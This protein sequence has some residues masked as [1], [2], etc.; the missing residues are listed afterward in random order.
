[1]MLCSSKS[2]IRMQIHIKKNIEIP[3]SVDAL[4]S[5]G[6]P[7]AGFVRE[8]YTIELNVAASGIN[9]NSALVE[10][11]IDKHRTACKPFN[12]MFQVVGCIYRTLHEA[13]FCYLIIK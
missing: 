5:T 6:I 4:C 8:R 1:M 2:P 9:L 12:A 3:F 7:A 11:R 10:D 13:T